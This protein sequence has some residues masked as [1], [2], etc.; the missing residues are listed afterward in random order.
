MFLSYGNARTL[1][2]HSCGN[3]HRRELLEEQLSSIRN[4]DLRDL[5][6]VLARPAFE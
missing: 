4:V 1:R 6:L 2:E 5:R 3:V